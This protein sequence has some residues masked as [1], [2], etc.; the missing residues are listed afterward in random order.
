MLKTLPLL[1]ETRKCPI[2]KPQSCKETAWS[3]KLEKTEMTKVIKKLKKMRNLSKK[4]TI[5]CDIQ[6][7]K[8]NPWQ[9]KI[10]SNLLSK[11]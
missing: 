1:L 8:P 2:N 6:K 7:L 3:L 4:I 11:P 9:L 5:I 10:F